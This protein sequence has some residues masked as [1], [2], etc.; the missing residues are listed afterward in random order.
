MAGQFLHED[1]DKPLCKAVKN[2]GWIFK[3]L[4]MPE[5]YNNFQSLH[6]MEPDQEK[7]LCGRQKS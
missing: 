7:E 1:P 3:I 2:E 4:K 6:V 5:P